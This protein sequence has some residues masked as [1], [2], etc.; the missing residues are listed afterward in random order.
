MIQHWCIQRKCNQQVMHHLHALCRHGLC[1]WAFFCHTSK[2]HK[3]F[4]W[5]TP[6]HTHT[7]TH[8]HTHWHTHTHT[9]THT[10]DS[11]FTMQLRA[12]EQELVQH[13]CVS[14]MTCLSSWTKASVPWQGLVKIIIETI[15]YNKSNTANT[16][17]ID[18]T[19][20]YAVRTWNLHFSVLTPLTPLFLCFFE[21]WSW[22]VDFC[23]VPQTEA[24]CRQ[25][26]CAREPLAPTTQHNPLYILTFVFGAVAAA[27]AVIVVLKTLNR[28]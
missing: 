16:M 2:H 27:E 8:T 4:S 10:G 23:S 17:N 22:P 1:C 3:K 19:D 24:C 28:R 13:A 7:L 18:L 11:T 9:D 6:A 14:A 25:Q 12:L 26:S 5:N 15:I 20:E 21:S